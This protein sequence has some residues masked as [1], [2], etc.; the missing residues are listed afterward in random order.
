MG[1]PEA[2]QTLAYYYAEGVGVQKNPELSFKWC[3]LSAENGFL[4]A[5]AELGRKYEDGNGVEKI[6]PLHFTGQ[7]KLPLKET[8]VL[9]AY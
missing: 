2:Q 5:K 8:L 1:C 4:P 3:K 9:N 7:R 6:L